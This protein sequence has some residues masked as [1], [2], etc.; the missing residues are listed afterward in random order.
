MH[1]NIIYKLTKEWIHICIA[2]KDALY[3]MNQEI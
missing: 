1:Y 2:M 3:L